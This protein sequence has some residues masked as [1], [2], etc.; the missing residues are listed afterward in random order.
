MTQVRNAGCIAVLL[1]FGI[2]C[3]SVPE[4]E[5]RLR[6]LQFHPNMYVVQAGDTLQSVAYRYRLKPAELTALNPEV[7]QGLSPGMRI[8]VRPGTSLSESVRSR[9]PLPRGN[10]QL[11]SVDSSWP[12]F[13]HERSTPEVIVAPAEPLSRP[14]IISRTTPRTPIESAHMN[15]PDFDAARRMV[16]EIPASARAASTSDRGYPNEEIIPD[17]LE[18]DEQF[19]DRDL[20]STQQS[21]TGEQRITPRGQWIWPTAGQIARGFAPHKVGGQG[22]DIAGVPGQDVRAASDGTVVYSGRDLSGGGNLII[23]RHADDLMTTYSHA[24]SLFVTEDD[25]VRAGDPIASLGWNAKRE[26]VLRFEVRRDGN[27]LNPIN[28]LP[29]N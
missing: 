22:V 17:T 2:G 26:S 29:V 8:N 15:A 3:T 27:P 28:F 20:F 19:A 12:V 10:T 13:A 9:A 1:L 5:S 25:V 23:V 21:S 18:V 4:M 6:A 7:A 16:A 24:D 11:N 14:V